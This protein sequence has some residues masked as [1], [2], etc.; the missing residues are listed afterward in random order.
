MTNSM[1]LILDNGRAGSYFEFSWA[2]SI[3]SRFHGLCARRREPWR[4]H[5]RHFYL[6]EP[7]PACPPPY[8][9]CTVFSV[10]RLYKHI[11]KGFCHQLQESLIDC[12]SGAFFFFQEES[13]STPALYQP[14]LKRARH[15]IQTS[16]AGGSSV[17]HPLDKF[18][19][20]S[21]GK[22]ITLSQTDFGTLTPPKSCLIASNG[23][24]SATTNENRLLLMMLCQHH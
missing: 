7:P 14:S 15:V 12:V 10:C 13:L 4:E 16:P 3:K 1:R 5:C 19:T 24:V 2:N 11:S 20:A 6:D 8:F 18:Q 21:A 22:T 9:S 17:T 23:I